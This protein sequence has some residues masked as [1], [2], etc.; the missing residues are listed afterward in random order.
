MNSREIDKNF[1]YIGE[2]ISR[3]VYG[4]DDN[5]VIKLA[6]GFDGRYQSNVEKYIYTNVNNYFRDYLCPIVWFKPGMTV[7]MRALPL[8]NNIHHNRV[9]LSKVIKDRDCKNDLKL[10]SNTFGLLYGDIEARSSWG[11][12]N[13]IPVLVDYGCTKKFYIK[14]LI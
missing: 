12:L 13:G 6:K 8:K 2:G 4:I 11:V 9:N 5:Y 14:Y 7:M 3:V 1:E 10:L